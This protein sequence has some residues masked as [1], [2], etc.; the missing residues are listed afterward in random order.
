MKKKDNA[1]AYTAVEAR[2]KQNKPEEDAVSKLRQQRSEKQYNQEIYKAQRKITKRT[3]VPVIAPEPELK[4]AD[5]GDGDEDSRDN[6]E[7]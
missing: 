4:E 3:A 2:Q 7:R 5:Q 1:Q 6:A